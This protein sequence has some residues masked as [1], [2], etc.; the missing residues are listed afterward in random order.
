MGF[1]KSIMREPL[2]SD[3]CHELPASLY[4]N[5]AATAACIARTGWQSLTQRASSQRRTY[6]PSRAWDLHLLPTASGGKAASDGKAAP[7]LQLIG[8]S[9]KTWQSLDITQ[10]KDQCEAQAPVERKVGNW[11]SLVVSIVAST[12]LSQDARFLDRIP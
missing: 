11:Q 8:G 4:H 7:G 5:R 10:S 2:F 1:P 3:R 6:G 12:K 9:S